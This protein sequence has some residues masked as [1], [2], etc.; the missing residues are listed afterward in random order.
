MVNIQH[1]LLDL[2][3]TLTDPK[4][5]IHGSIRYALAKMNQPL[6]DDVDLN[7][8]IGPPLKP[9]LATLLNTHD[10][11]RAEQALQ[12][13]RERFAD[14]GL[15]ENQ[16]YDGVAETLV[17]LQQRGYKLY[18]ATAKPQVYARKILQHF[19]LLKYFTQ[20]YG[21]ELTGERTDK[22]DLIHY[23]LQQE[24]LNAETCMMVGDRKYDILGARRNQ[25]QSIAVNYGYGTEEELA[26]AEV[27]HCISHFS[28]L[29][30]LLPQSA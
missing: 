2:D 18:L 10:D 27:Q 17:K 9:S 28:E 29:L 6:S 4:Q 15:Y 26:E 19:D 24:Q 1:L 30:N 13:Y 20:A 16:V 12:Y 3:G 14:I 11:A 25:M 23:I 22:G 5:G 21:S 7:W 8:T